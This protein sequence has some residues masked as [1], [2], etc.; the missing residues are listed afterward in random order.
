MAKVKGQDVVLHMGEDNFVVIC[1]RSITFNIE[2]EIIET[3][4]S[5]SGQFRTYKKGA[6]NWSGEIEGLSY[7]VNGTTDDQTVEQFYFRL[8]DGEEVFMRWY[9]EDDAH[10]FNLNKYGY[11]I[12]TSVSEVSSFDNMVT[13]NASFKGTGPI[14]IESGNV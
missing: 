11:C 14:T 4:I 8:L 2:R 9:E 10:Q 1:G 7:L 6:I 12:I 13:F 5:N 3:S